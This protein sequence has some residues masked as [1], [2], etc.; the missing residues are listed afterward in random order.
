MSLAPRP[1]MSIASRWANQRI[2]SL[3]WSGQRDGG[4]GAVEVD[5]ARARARPGAPQLGQVVGKSKGTSVP[6]RASTSTRTTC[7]MI[8]PAF[9]ITTVSPIRTSLR[10]ISSALCRLARLTV[11]PASGTGV[12]VGDRGQLAGLAD[13]DGDPDDLRDRL[14]GLV[15]EGDHP[16]RALA[17]RP[18][19]RRAGRGRRP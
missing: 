7:G 17:P 5:L 9:W 15:L 4:V 12:E 2:H 16:A 14:L 3:S 18:Q 19:P 8:S 10:R 6:S 1:S 11:V 13:L